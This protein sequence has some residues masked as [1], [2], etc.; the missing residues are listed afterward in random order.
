M[1]E[2]YTALII[3]MPYLPIIDRFFF[4]LFFWPLSHICL[5][6]VG[7]FEIEFYILQECLHNRSALLY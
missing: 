5:S 1:N 3:L 2:R 7:R 6:V 4:F